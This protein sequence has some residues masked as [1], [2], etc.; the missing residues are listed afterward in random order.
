[1]CFLDSHSVLR[2]IVALGAAHP[3][4][5]SVL[6]SFCLSQLHGLASHPI[7]GGMDATADLVDVHTL[8]VVVN[9]V[10]CTSRVPMVWCLF[11]ARGICVHKFVNER[12]AVDWAACRSLFT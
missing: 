2:H 10:L 5:W 3:L 4:L 12:A 9:S 7:G 6:P 1:M 11:F 8:C